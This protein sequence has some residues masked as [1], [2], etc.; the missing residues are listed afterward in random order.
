MGRPKELTE[1]ERADLL[2]KV[3]RSLEV[4]VIDRDNPAYRADVARQLDDI[5]AADRNEPDIDDWIVG[6]RGNLWDD[7]QS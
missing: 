1:E 5:T 4:G 6:I 7:E 2:A 3:W